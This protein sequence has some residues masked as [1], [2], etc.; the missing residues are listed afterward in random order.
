MDVPKHLCSVDI[1]EYI[2][3]IDHEH[4]PTHIL[5]IFLPEVIFFMNTPLYITP[6]YQAHMIYASVKCVI[7]PTNLDNTFLY[8]ALYNFLRFLLGGSMG[9]CQDQLICL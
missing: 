2:S 3:G 9:T 5:L 4:S 8:N 1:V 6:Q 7:L